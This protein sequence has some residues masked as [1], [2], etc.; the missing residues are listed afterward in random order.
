M[1]FIKGAMI[2]MLAG[3]VVGVMNSDSLKG[4]MKKGK[5]TF[6]KMTKNIGM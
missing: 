3:A 1:N 6:K 2:G 5:N 4:M